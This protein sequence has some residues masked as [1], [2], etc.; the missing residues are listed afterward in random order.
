MYKQLNGKEVDKLKIAPL[1]KGAMIA[2]RDCMGVNKEEKVAVITDTGKI[3][4]AQS[5]LFALHALGVD[6]TLFLMIPR[7]H[8]AEEPPPEIGI[9]MAAVDVAL[10]V[11]TVSLSHTY[12]RMEATRKGVRIAS[13]PGIT[14]DMLTAGAMT[15]DYEKVSELSWK[16]TRLLETTDLVEISTEKGTDLRLS[17]KGRNPAIPPDDGLY[18]ERGRWGNLP[19]GEAFIA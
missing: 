18:R 15:A 16:L 2:V 12:A 3:D 5:F 10:L 1:M 17:L 8:H 14:E 7:S 4:I 6:A 13:M 9:A 11:T 19:A